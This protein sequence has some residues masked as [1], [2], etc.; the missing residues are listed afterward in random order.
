[1]CARHQPDAI[2]YC[3][4]FTN[5]DGCETNRD[6][7]FKVNAL[8]RA[9]SGHGRRRK[10]G[11]E[12]DPCFH[13]LCVQRRGERRN[14]AGRVP[15][16]RLRF[17]C[18]RLRQSCWA[19][20]YVTEAFCSRYFIVRTAWLYGAAGK[21]FVKTMRATWPR[22]MTQMHGCQ[23]SA[24]QPHQRGGSGLSSAEAVRQLMST[25][26]T[27]APASGVCSLVRLCTR[28]IIRLSGV[29]ATRLL[30]AFPVPS[31][32]AQHPESRQ[33]PRPGARWKTGCWRCTVGNEMR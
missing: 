11:R 30:P 26:S 19:K 15:P 14:P 33:P 20:Q 18:V 21:N 6:A 16:C 8:G 31:T 24:G 27:T 9:Q 28:E 29:E 1:M 23:R 17:Q 2:I 4:A 13:R 22:R 10:V 25:A 5:V 3:A 7:A 32:P 12:P